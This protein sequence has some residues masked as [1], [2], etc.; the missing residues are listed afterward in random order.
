[1]TQN[2]STWH[3][4]VAAMIEGCMWENGCEEKSASGMQ[5]VNN[6]DM[7]HTSSLIPNHFFL[8]T[9]LLTGPNPFSPSSRRPFP[10]PAPPLSSF[11]LFSQEGGETNCVISEPLSHLSPACLTPKL[12]SSCCHPLFPRS[13]FLLYFLTFPLS[14][15]ITLSLLSPFT[16][17]HS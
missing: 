8:A 12:Y 11:I 14:V 1:M 6:A 10:P 17:L 15:I 2:V 3:L 4:S 16:S 9:I 5:H 7:P 13:P